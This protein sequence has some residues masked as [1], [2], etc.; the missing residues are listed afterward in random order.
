MND[1]NVASK[2]QIAKCH[3]IFYFNRILQKHETCVMT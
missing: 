2:M 3:K 1:K